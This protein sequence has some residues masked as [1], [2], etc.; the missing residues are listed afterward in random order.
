MTAGLDRVFRVV[1]PIG[2]LVRLTVQREENV[3]GGECG[4]INFVACG[5]MLLALFLCFLTFPAFCS[6]FCHLLLAEQEQYRSD[7]LRPAH[8][9]LHTI[10][11]CIITDCVET[12][13]IA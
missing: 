4:G 13:Q 11:P 12:R 6:G 2:P 1:S 9:S 7:A 8:P 3:W 5:R 10:H